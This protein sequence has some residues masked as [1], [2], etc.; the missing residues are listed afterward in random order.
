MEFK[1]VFV[2]LI[3]LSSVIGLILHQFLVYKHIDSKRTLIKERHIN[4]KTLVLYAFM[5][6]FRKFDHSL[7]LNYFIELGVGPDDPAD[8]VF[9]IQGYKC[10]VSIPNYPNIRIYKRP[11]NCYDF[12][13]YGDTI[14]WLGG[15]E[16]LK[17]KYHSFIFL[18]PTAL[19]PI[20]PKYWPPDLHWSKIFT[21][22]MKGNV[23]AVGVTL[24][25]EGSSHQCG[26]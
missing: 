15:I 10:S 7:S 11:N 19:G 18:N 2:F 5:D 14:N 3:I 26:P 23:H 1:K 22:M 16:A 6:K 13:A 17:E 9:I 20:L 4:K 8:Y 21:S 24:F 12:G 25:C